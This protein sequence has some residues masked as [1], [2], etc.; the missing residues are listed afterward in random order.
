MK[1]R[2][3]KSELGGAVFVMVFGTLLHFFYEWSGNNPVVALFAPYNESTW[4]HLKLLFF[5]VL[6]YSLFQYRYIGKQYFGYITGRLAGVLCGALLIVLVFYGYMAIFGHS[7]LWIDI[8]LFY[9]SV[10]LCYGIAYIITLWDR[11]P[12]WAEF[13]SG[14][15]LA[16]IVLLFFVRTIQSQIFLLH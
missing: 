16:G 12:R 2:L 15:A 3:K 14:V 1:H 5:P 8:S 10:V 4:E 9:V 13:L 11:I 7:I 6:F